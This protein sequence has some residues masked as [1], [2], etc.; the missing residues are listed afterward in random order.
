[1]TLTLSSSRRDTITKHHTDV[2][3]SLAA[4]DYYLD[5][6]CLPAAKATLGFAMYAKYFTVNSSIPCDTGLGC[7][8]VLLEAADGSD[9]G[10]SGAMTFEASNYASA[11][12]NLTESTDG[13]C[14]AAS[15]TFCP[16]G[17]CCS[18]YG[19]WYDYHPLP[20]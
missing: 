13:A 4:V 5:T 9:T 18:A 12:T 16:T 3:G 19:F 2:N 20:F 8:T 17:D 7:E 1:M 11:P 6:L 10:K 14:G 15:F